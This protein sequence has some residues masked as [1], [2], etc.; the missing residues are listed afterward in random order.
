MRLLISALEPSANLHLKPVLNELRSLISVATLGQNGDGDLELCGIFSSDFGTP[1]YDSSEFSAMGFVEVLP[2]IFKAKRAIKQMVKIAKSCDHALLIDSPAFNLPLAKALK[3]SGFKGKITYYILPQVWA[4]K[5]HRAKIVREY[6]DNLASI[7]PFELGFYENAIYV[8]NPL[9]DELD[10]EMA[11]EL[12]GDKIAF[13]PGSRKSEIARLMPIF[14]QVATEIKGDKILVIPPHLKDKIDE[15]YGD[16]SGFEAVFDT[17]KALKMA[18]FS[19]ICSGTATLEAALLG[20][21]FVL[22]YKAKKIDIWLARKFVKL[23]FVGLANI[24]LDFMGKAPLHAE[25]IG[26]EVSVKS[27]LRAYETS[28]INSFKAASLKLREYLQHGASQHLAKIILK[29]F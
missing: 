14:K 11:T 1:L 21:P 16:I 28:D 10:F 13:L 5:A 20:A 23:K 4:W 22:C 12:G 27:L 19:F 2:L 8:G 7:W 18:K 29:E 9:L 3:K 17:A 26:E 15:F 24:L 25:L 6:C